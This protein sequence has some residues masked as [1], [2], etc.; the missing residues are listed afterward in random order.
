MKIDYKFLFFSIV[1]AIGWGYYRDLR[2]GDI[3]SFI[4]RLIFIVIFTLV[5][6]FILQK[7]HNK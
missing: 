3:N 6:Q 2:N 7:F 1:F 4:G 5:L